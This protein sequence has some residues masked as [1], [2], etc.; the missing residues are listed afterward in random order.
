MFSQLWCQ[1]AARPLTW[2]EY[3][4]LFGVLVS[5]AQH[6]LALCWLPAAM[7]SGMY[8]GI[9]SD[10]ILPAPGGTGAYISA[11]NKCK[12]GKCG[13]SCRWHRHCLTWKIREAVAK[14]AGIQNS[15]W[16][17]RAHAIKFS[18]TWLYI[19]WL[20]RKILPVFQ[21]RFFRLKS[22]NVFYLHQQS[23]HQFNTHT[24][25]STMTCFKYANCIAR[26]RNFGFT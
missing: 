14:A 22:K 16:N 6:T 13:I 4:K 9:S 20:Q 19:G 15:H 1:V 12:V 23:K 25:L 24:S 17:K 26:H 10:E 18:S 5:A 2:S 3:T 7:L 21:K 11:G 8:V